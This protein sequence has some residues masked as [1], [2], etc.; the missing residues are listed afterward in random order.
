MKI[1]RCTHLAL[2]SLLI[3]LSS[4][5]RADC[6]DHMPEPLRSD[7]IVVEGAGQSF[8]NS[9]YAY[10][11]EYEQWLTEQAMNTKPAAGSVT[12]NPAEDASAVMENT[13]Q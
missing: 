3:T 12:R 2:A 10:Q 5:S 6:P 7:C 4:T 8:P 11:A 9:T 1:H 13:P